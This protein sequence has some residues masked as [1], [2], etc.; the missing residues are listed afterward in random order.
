M[1][2]F[3]GYSGSGTVWGDLVYVNY[4]TQEDFYV[5]RNYSISLN[6]SIAIIRYGRIFRGSKVSVEKYRHY[7]FYMLGECS[8]F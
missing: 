8:Q 7:C 5:L 6:N 3:L 1:P 2:S 4:G